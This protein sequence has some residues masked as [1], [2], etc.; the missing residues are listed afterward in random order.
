MS[1]LKI[2]FLIGLISVNSLFANSK[3]KELESQLL[4]GA[5]AT[6]TY[7]GRSYLDDIFVYGV[8][9]KSDDNAYYGFGL[10]YDL[11]DYYYNVENHIDFKKAAFI[12]KIDFND[13]FYNK[14]GFS[15]L[16][17]KVSI[18]DNYEFVKQ[19]TSGVSLGF[20]DTNTYNFEVGYIINKLNDAF[21]ANTTTNTTFAEITFKE[22]YSFGAIDTTFSLQTSKAYD[23]R[24]KDYSGTLGYYPIDDIKTSIKY[25]SVEYSED[26]YNFIAGLNY[27][28]KNFSNFYE[29]TLNPLLNATL[30]N[31]NNIQTIFDYKYDIANRSL[32]I[33]DK[34]KQ[35][36]STAKIFA[37]KIN[38]SEFLRKTSEDKE[39]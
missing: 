30:N 11:N 21:H 10:K 32:K 16:D 38:P 26:E 23:K 28:F 13:K 27:R 4:Y 12:H 20:G 39:D 14:F 17:K 18:L 34:F 35:L 24:E 31:T 22:D 29:G 1:N 19:M 5:I 33:K 6:N 8:G 3:P 37:K 7:D 15:Y 25:N 2:L 36:I 9:T